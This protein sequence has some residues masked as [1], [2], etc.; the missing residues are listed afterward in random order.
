MRS[1]EVTPCDSE[2]ELLGLIDAVTEVSTI[3]QV[4]GA[5]RGPRQSPVA[6]HEGM[7]ASQRVHECPSL[8]LECGVRELAEYAC[9]RASSRR[10][11]QPDIT[12]LD[13]RQDALSDL[14]EVLESE[15]I[16]T[17]H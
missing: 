15:E 7:V 2:D 6:V 10:L 3:D 11:Q 16:D 8:I 12:D 1:I 5:N 17:V 13:G 9:S 4:E 14:N